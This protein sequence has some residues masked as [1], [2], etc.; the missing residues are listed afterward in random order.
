MNSGSV[1][2][3]SAG[4][5]VVSFLLPVLSRTQIPA[6]P[7]AASGLGS[8]TPSVQIGR[9]G[10]HIQLPQLPAKAGSSYQLPPH[11]DH[12]GTLGIE[13]LVKIQGG[14]GWMGGRCTGLLLE[15]PP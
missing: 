9:V 10:V 7:A 4:L 3:G 8:L 14:E 12:T 5:W 13:S 6:W 15:A 1:T 2:S 11:P